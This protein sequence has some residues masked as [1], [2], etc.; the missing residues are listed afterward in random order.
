LKTWIDFHVLSTLILRGWSILAGAVTVIGIP[1]WLTPSEQ[2]YYFTFASILASQIFFELGL[3]YVLTQFAA[4]EMRVLRWNLRGY[5]VGPVAAKAK[6]GSLVILASRIY[7]W[8]SIGFGF[9]AAFGGYIFFGSAP[10]PHPKYWEVSWMLCV[11]TAAGNLYLSPK[12]ALFEGIGQV[13]QVASLRTRLSIVGYC[14]AWAALAAGIG[15]LAVPIISGSMCV[16]SML[17]RA[18]KRLFLSNLSRTAKRHPTS[19]IYWKTEIWPLQWRIAVSWASGYLIFQLFNPILFKNFG[20]KEA[21]RVGLALS[22]C[23]SLVT[24]SLSWVTAKV[25]MI[26]QKIKSG[27][28]AE[29]KDIYRSQFRSSSISFAILGLGLIVAVAVL[30]HIPPIKERLPTVATTGFIVAASFSN[31]MVFSLAAYMRAFGVEPLMWPSL[32]TG[33]VTIVGLFSMGRYSVSAAMACYALVQ[34]FV[35]LPWVLYIFKSKFWGENNE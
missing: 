33:V 32:I 24:L 30:Q 34:I 17:W 26:V 3:N 6:L 12:L 10:G 16:G 35:C 20:P 13:G 22:I 8:L 18:Q 7:L 1:F 15:L 9:T 23:G 4:S 2:G 27:R 19:R 21:G 14:C 28:Y 11:L 29:A 5:V 31:Q 25:P